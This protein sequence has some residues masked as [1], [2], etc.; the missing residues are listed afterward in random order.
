MLMI[1]SSENYKYSAR[2]GILTAICIA[3]HWDSKSS[4]QWGSIQW[5]PTRS[6]KSNLAGSFPCKCTTNNNLDGTGAE[7]QLV[8]TKDDFWKDG[9]ARTWGDHHILQSE[10]RKVTDEGPGGARVCKRVSPEHPLECGDSSNEQGL[11]EHG[12]RGLAAGKPTV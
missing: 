5:S 8:Q 2:T 7:E 1:R 3:I 9:A 6:R 10:V 12:E 4:K 11:K